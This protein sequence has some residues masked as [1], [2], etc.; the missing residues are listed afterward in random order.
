MDDLEGHIKANKIDIEFDT[1]NPR[2]PQKLKLYNVSSLP[3]KI[4]LW[5]IIFLYLVSLVS[6]LTSIVSSL[7]CQLRNNSI[8]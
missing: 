8:L 6:N 3:K 2:E 4:Q 7:Q 5:L 1:I